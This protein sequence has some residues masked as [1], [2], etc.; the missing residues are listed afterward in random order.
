MHPVTAHGYN[1]GLSG[2]DILAREIIGAASRD[3]DI[4]ATT[5]LQR[6]QRKHMQTTRPMFH[7]TNEIVR[8]FTDDR[9]PAKLARKIALRLAD[10]LPP[11][12][13]LI[14]NKLTETTNGKNQ[15]TQCYRRT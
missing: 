6:Y 13:R 14:Q 1:L 12:K 7:G 15:D 8:F 5:L 3:G 11:I 4:G 9:A 2:Q 10:R